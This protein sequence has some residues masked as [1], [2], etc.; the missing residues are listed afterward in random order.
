LRFPAGQLRKQGVGA[1]AGVLYSWL[2]AKWQCPTLE[3]IETLATL[4]EDL[5]YGLR[6]LRNAPGFTLVALVSL[7]LGIGANTAIFSIVKAV[8]LKP[9]PFPDPDRLVTLWASNPHNPGDEIM[10]VT[11]ADFEDWRQRTHFFAEI[12][13]SYDVQKSLTGAGEPEALDGYAFAAKVF[14]VLGI[15]PLL[16]RTFTAEEDRLGADRVV[17]LAYSLWQSKFGGDRGVVGKAIVLDGQSYTVLG[18]MP[19]GFHY[20]GDCD[21]WVPIALQTRRWQTASCL[22]CGWWQGSSP[23]PVCSRPTPI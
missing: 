10:P 14:H 5:R 8:L 18:I 17:V 4:L 6:T 2:D 1:G 22:I 7:A 13:A 16:G 23:G 20:P 21:F 15:T 3:G 11:P 12:G 19:P 9:L